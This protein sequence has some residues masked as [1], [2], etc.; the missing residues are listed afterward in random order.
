MFASFNPE[1]D[2][3]K[4]F[5]DKAINSEKGEL[6]VKVWE[7]AVDLS[8]V[9]SG[10]YRASWQISIGGLS[11]TF[12]NTSSQP[13]SVPA[14]TAPSFTVAGRAMDKVFVTNGAPYGHFVEYGS[15]TNPAHHVA[16]RA[17]GAVL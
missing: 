12:N 16:H 17:V 4:E 1:I 3:T 15:P 10:R 5:I 7:K 8:P 9:F 11:F 13:N 2:D 14:P 6:A